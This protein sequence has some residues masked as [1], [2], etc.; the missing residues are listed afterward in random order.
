MDKVKVSI[1][2]E[3]CSYRQ[4]EGLK[5]IYNELLSLTDTVEV[6][7]DRDIIKEGIPTDV[8]DRYDFLTELMLGSIE[9]SEV[10]VVFA[11]TIEEGGFCA[12]GCIL[13]Y[14]W[15]QGVQVV[16]VDLTGSSE[17]LHPIAD[18]VIQAYLTSLEA[19]STYNFSEM[20]YVPSNRK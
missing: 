15:S 17:V 9:K 8:D 7:A 19:I 6:V 1:A 4:I 13:G 5:D 2:G 14:C 12:L 3:G 18:R 10:C 11:P 16:L 20:P